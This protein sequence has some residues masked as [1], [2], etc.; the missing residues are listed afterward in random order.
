MAFLTN[1]YASKQT[2][3]SWVLNVLVIMNSTQITREYE[4]LDL[5]LRFVSNHHLRSEP[6]GKSI[7]DFPHEGNTLLLPCYCK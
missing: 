4:M 6:I 7:P 2:Q 1:V 3:L 5:R